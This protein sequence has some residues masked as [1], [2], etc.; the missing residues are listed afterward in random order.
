MT[1]STIALK[2]GRNHHDLTGWLRPARQ[3]RGFAKSM[4]E[5]ADVLEKALQ[6]SCTREV[7][8]DCYMKFTKACDLFGISWFFQPNGLTDSRAVHLAATNHLQL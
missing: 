2:S 7:F 6:V 4:L 5:V 8:C 1:F 3:V